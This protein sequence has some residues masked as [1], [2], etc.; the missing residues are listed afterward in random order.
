[1]AEFARSDRPAQGRRHPLP[2]A[3]PCRRPAVR[4][5]LRGGAAGPEAALRGL[6]G[7]GRPL[8]KEQRAFFEARLGTDLGEVRLHTDGDSRML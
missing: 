8:P 1:M 2:V 4:A 5:V 7:R 3:A 6:E